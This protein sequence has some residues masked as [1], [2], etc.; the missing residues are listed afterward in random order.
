MRP[1]V[2]EHEYPRRRGSPCRS[3]QTHCHR[4]VSAGNRKWG[5]ESLADRPSLCPLL[6]HRSSSYVSGRGALFALGTGWPLLATKTAIWTVPRGC[7]VPEMTAELKWPLRPMA[8]PDGHC[9]EA[10]PSQT[11]RG[12]WV[13]RMGSSETCTLHL[14]GLMPTSLLWPRLGRMCPVP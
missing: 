3:G 1:T 6:L 12:P 8:A 7:R 2:G 11:W 14:L 13:G 4:A 10:E 9:L 5:L